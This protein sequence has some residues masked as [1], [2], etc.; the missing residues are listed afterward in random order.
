MK[1][2]VAAILV[3]LVLIQVCLLFKQISK[4]RKGEDSYYLTI[5]ILMI[6]VV[7]LLISAMSR[8]L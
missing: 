8:F 2:I 1:I 5:P 7:V 4:Y 6:T 3:V